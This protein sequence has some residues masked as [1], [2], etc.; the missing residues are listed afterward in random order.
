[1]SAV[2][3]VLGKPEENVRRVEMH[4]TVQIPQPFWLYRIQPRPSATADGLPLHLTPGV[5]AQS[6][7]QPV[8]TSTD[9]SDV[10][11]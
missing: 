3:V 4:E 6:G 2:L 7:G 9:L 8:G 5:A 1:M 10:G 11:M